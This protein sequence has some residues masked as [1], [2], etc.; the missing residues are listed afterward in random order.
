MEITSNI[1]YGIIIP[2]D[3]G[4]IKP[5]SGTRS[6]E[7]VKREYQFQVDWNTEETERRAEVVIKQKEGKLEKRIIVI[8]KAQAGY[9]GNTDGDIKDDLKVPVS[10]GTASSY[11]P[12]GEIE[13][14]FDDDRSTLYHSSW[15]NA[16]S[17]YFPITLEY[18]FEN[19]ESI[20][21]LVYYPRTTGP[22]GLFKKAEI[23]VATEDNPSYIKVMDYDFQGVSSPTRVTFAKTLVKPQSIK[24]VVQSGA[25]DGQG[26]AS[27]AEM[28]FYRVNPDNT[29][30]L[31]LFTD[32]TCTQLKPGIT[33]EEIEKV[34]NNLYRNIALYMLKGTYPREFRIQTYRAWPHPDDWARVN[35]TS[36]LSLLD[37]PTGI[38]VAENEEMV[39][40]VSDTGGYP[41]SLKIQNLNKPG[42]DGYGN[43]S[44][45]PLS[46]G[47][48][49]FKARN[50]GLVY[51]FYHTPNYKSAP[52][53][54][55]HFA[56]GKVNGYFDSQKHQSSDWP[57]LLNAAVD[58]YF[59]LLG[60]HAHL[61]FPTND[62][63]T[64][65]A[66]NGDKLINA[67]DDLVR[68]EKE[69]MGLMKYNRP[70]VNRA[71]FHAMYTSF[72]YSTSYR[73]AY[74]V[75]G[76]DVKRAILDL[77]Q[78]KLSPWGPAHET[79]HTFQTRPGFKWHGMTE[80]TNNVHS[81][82]V[83]TQWGNPSRIEE[84]N[85]ERYNN[86]YEKAYHNYFVQNTP[87]P[88]E[89]DVFCK[90]IPLWQLQLY[91]ANARGNTD[92]YKDLYEKI[93][94]S[95]DKP[96]PGGQQLEF[97]KIMCDVTG[98]DLTRFF[99]LWGFYSPFD[100][101]VDDYGKKRITI[102]QTQI[103]RTIADIKAKG[104]PEVDEKIE[105]ICDA[106]WEV[107]KNRLQVQAGTA[108]KSGSSITMTGWKNVVAY[109]VYEGDKMMF[110]SNR[111]SFNVDSAVTN[112]IKVYA[113][114]YD[115]TKTEVLF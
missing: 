89:G 56:T 50:K 82:Y 80:V 46:P 85:L 25:G 47:V 42:G 48:N 28:E 72:M 26:F 4:W 7:M 81:L 44:F 19:Q 60:E 59:D 58:D 55:I 11:Q 31:T 84:E 88:G 115:G 33:L 38:S 2:D 113:I 45:Y 102:T 15:N 103:D 51:L 20:D 83:Q 71:Y 13:K 93:R 98:R 68:L 35:K 106:N 30:P 108:T 95:P 37:N 65:A 64:Y 14:S 66:D 90:L 91:F 99:R 94:T 70:T 97:T 73:T 78:F 5:K 22:N 67:Y 17:N 57:R 24:F 62:L 6:V 100:D 39:V 27:C 53:V 10:R 92:V 86:R 40:F 104:Y 43:A 12:G 69:F 63:K 96:T 101:E 109:E 1:E 23:W 61:T 34:S 87:Y 16:G 18:F 75:S 110:V 107:F 52:D 105:Y 77:K 111:A 9:S 76:A 74:N 21:Y 41:L 32:L 29:D 112:A 8:Q 49:K 79:G 36:T 114:A 3:A 54:K